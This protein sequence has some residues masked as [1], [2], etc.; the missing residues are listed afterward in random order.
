MA[1]RFVGVCRF[2]LRSERRENGALRLQTRDERELR[3]GSALCA[4]EVR[5]TRA[6]VSLALRYQA[7][8]DG[9]NNLIALPQ[10]VNS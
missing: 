1:T 5:G 6:L 4:F 2:P 8:A 9:F 10:I 3:S 7:S